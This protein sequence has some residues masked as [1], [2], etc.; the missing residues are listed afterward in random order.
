MRPF[1]F[2][3]SYTEWLWTRFYAHTK[4]VTESSSISFSGMLSNIGKVSSA[5]VAQLY[6]SLSPVFGRREGV[7]AHVPS[8][9]LCDFAKV[10]V[11]AG[12]HTEVNLSCRPNSL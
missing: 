8:R 12:Q 7:S 10:F 2:G 1:G 4:N 5:Q 11:E 9:Q 3:L 6:A